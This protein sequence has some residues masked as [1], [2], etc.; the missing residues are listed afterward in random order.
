M[1]QF[2]D[3]NYEEQDGL[4]TR[5]TLDLYYLN[6]YWNFITTDLSTEEIA[7]LEVAKKN[8]QAYEKLYSLMEYGDD[9]NASLT[10]L[11]T[12]VANNNPSVPMTVYRKVILLL[13]ISS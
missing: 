6:K 12:R 10:V 9:L 1:G 8:L 5:P 3:H 13:H 11:S 7:D 2:A 4:Y